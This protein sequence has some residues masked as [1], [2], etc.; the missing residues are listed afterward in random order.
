MFRFIIATVLTWEGL[1]KDFLT[2]DRG[3]ASHSLAFLEALRGSEYSN[4]RSIARDGAYCFKLR[5]VFINLS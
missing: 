3:V 4:M 1:R 5:L 2:A